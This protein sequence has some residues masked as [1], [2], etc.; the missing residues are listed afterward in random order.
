MPYKYIS[1]DKFVDYDRDYI[2]SRIISLTELR[3]RRDEL[4]QQK[5]EIMSITDV[6]LLEWARANHPKLKNGP[7]N[8]IELDDKIERLNNLITKLEGIQ[9]EELQKEAIVK[10]SRL[11]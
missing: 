5:N 8:I 10:R 3:Q 6:E 2:R 4:I 11:P 7:S 1:D 9:A